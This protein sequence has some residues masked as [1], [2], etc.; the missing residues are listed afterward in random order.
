MKLL[1]LFS[2]RILLARKWISLSAAV[3]IASL[4]PAAAVAGAKSYPNVLSVGPFNNPSPEYFYVD[5]K[6]PFDP[7]A[8]PQIQLTAY[9]YGDSNKALDVTIGWYMWNSAFYWTQYHSK[10]GFN[11]PSRIRLGTYDDAGTTRVRIEI[12]NDGVYWSS[13][14]FSAT[15]V[16]GSDP[17]Y[18]GWSYAEGEMPSSTGLVEIVP[19]QQDV[20]VHGNL[21]VAGFSTGDGVIYVKPQDSTLEGGHVQLQRAASSQNH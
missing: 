17:N 3:L 9:M 2:R 20:Q 7:G 14:F 19:L 18:T 13:Y 11:N 5:T 16:L 21:D 6:I 10:L 8:A 12:A 15:D 1:G 4:L